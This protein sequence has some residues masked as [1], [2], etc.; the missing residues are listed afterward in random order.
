MVCV[1]AQSLLIYNARDMHSAL[2]RIAS[3]VGALYPIVPFIALFFALTMPAI[4]SPVGA[5]GVWFI[6]AIFFFSSLKVDGVKV[7]KQLTDIRMLFVSTAM[8]LFIFPALVYWVLSSLGSPLALPLMI[9]AALPAGMTSPLLAELAGGRPS[10]AMVITT[11]TSLLAPFTIP[12]VIQFLAGTVVKVSVVAMMFSL[13]KVIF[14]PFFLAQLIRH[15][16]SEQKITEASFLFKP[17]SVVL[18]GMLIAGVVARQSGPIIAGLYDGTTFVLVMQLTL[19]FVILHILGYF[20]LFWRDSRDKV[21]ASVCLTYM[22]FTLGILLADQYFNIPSV[23]IPIV[24]AVVPWAVLFV[25][26]RFAVARLG[27]IPKTSE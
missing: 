14:I 15:T 1:A 9:L 24:L 16:V 23:V 11:V 22:N 3:F 5:H 17:I 10:L 7:L 25:P 12:I 21:T 4:F 19:F 13:A 20:S 26:F 18:L 8:M 27:L 6:A 2:R